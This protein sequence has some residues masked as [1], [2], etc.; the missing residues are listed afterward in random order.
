MPED[1]EQAVLQPFC[2]AVIQ[3]L[4]RSLQFFF[5]SSEYTSLD[6]IVLC[7][8]VASI[9]GLGELAEERLSTP[10]IVANPFAGMT[11][12][13]RVDAQALAQDAPA[14]MVA[15]GLAMRGVGR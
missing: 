9:G 13:P 14:M 3:Q 11:V 2:E 5:S 12:G 8:G 15:C 7:G 6:C 10:V 4:S 1:Y